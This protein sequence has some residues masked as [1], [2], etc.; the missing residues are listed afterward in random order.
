MG[1]FLDHIINLPA[2][3]V[4]LIVGALVFAE[5]ALFVGFLLPGETAAILGGVTAKLGHTDLAV[6][7]I[8]VVLAAILGD[9]VGY[10]IGHRYGVRLLNVGWL[11]RRRT[12]ID[13]ARD[14]LA[15]RGGPAVFIGRWVAF[16][17]AITPLLAGTAHMRYRTF[18]IY[19]IAGGVVWGV[20][21]VLIGYLAGASYQAVAHT[22]GTVSAIVVAA[23]VV[24]GLIV[25]RVREHRSR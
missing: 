20:A 18:L 24:I 17:R 15:R 23:I 6:V 14:L 19:N 10:L 8:T 12:Q 16:L 1:S 11:A 22:F 9:N 21:V 25:W 2:A 7:M 4:Y 5:D 13:R 3:W